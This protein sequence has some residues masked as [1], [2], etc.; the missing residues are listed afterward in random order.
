MKKLSVFVDADVLFAGAASPS[1]HSASQVVLM[2]GEITLVD[3]VTSVQVVTEIERNLQAKLPSKLPEMRL[4]IS[5]SLKII[6]DPSPS[7]LESYR[8]WADPK[9]LPILVAALQHPCSTLLT[10]NLR[11]Y[12]PPRDAISIMRPGDFLQVIR[13]RLAGRASGG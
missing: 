4:L 10:F 9:D 3:L 1:E 12:R 6:P 2:L 7:D 13:E 5:R 8:D 11:H